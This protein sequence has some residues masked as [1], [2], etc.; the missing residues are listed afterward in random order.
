M[1]DKI[2]IFLGAVI[3]ILGIYMAIAPKS[4]TKKENRDN[5]AEVQK[6]RKNGFIMIAIGIMDIVI[7]LI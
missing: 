1:Y 6:V 3:I 4:A 2:P 5:E 7:W